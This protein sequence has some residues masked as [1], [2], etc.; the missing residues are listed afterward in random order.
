MPAACVSNTCSVK[1]WST[2]EM[3][4]IRWSGGLGVAIASCTCKTSFMKLVASA[5]GNQ[6]I[7]DQKAGVV[8]QALLLADQSLLFQELCGAFKSLSRNQHHSPP[9]LRGRSCFCS[10]RKGPCWKLDS[11]PWAV[12]DRLALCY[13][14]NESLPWPEPC[15]CCTSLALLHISMNQYIK[16]SMYKHGPFP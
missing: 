2:W 1:P 13:M 3:K 11:H 15:L 9:Q 8:V 4:R 16:T 14:S 12:Q 5:D 7:H 10:V 6:C